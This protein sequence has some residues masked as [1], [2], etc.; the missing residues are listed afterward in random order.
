MNIQEMG[1]RFQVNNEY[2]RDGMRTEQIH[3]EIC[4]IMCMKKHNSADHEG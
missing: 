3:I 2:S 4:K 1:C